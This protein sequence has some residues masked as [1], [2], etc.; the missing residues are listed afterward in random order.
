[1]E[2]TIKPNLLFIMADQFRWDGI[3]CIGNWTRTPH[4]NRLAGEGITFTQCV[5][6]SP[7]CL[8]ARTA[9]ATGLYPHQTGVWTNIRGYDLPENSRTWMQDVQAAGYRTS[10]F[11]KSHHHR[12]QG[13]LRDREYLMRAYGFED[14]HEI[15]GPR[16]S[17]EARSD[18]TDEWERQGLWQ[19]YIEDYEERYANKPYVARPSPLP[20]ALY[21]DIYVAQK[22]K[23]YLTAYEDERPWCCMLSFGG[24][25]EPWDTPEPYASS[26]NPK[27]MPKAIAKLTGSMQR[28]QGML[29]EMMAKP[30]YA[31][32]MD[33]QEIALLRANYAGNISLIDDQIGEVLGV[34]EKR[35]ELDNTVIVFTSDHGEMNGDF[36]L[37][38]KSNFLKSSAQVPLIVRTPATRTSSQAG[39]LL[40]T[41][42]ELMDVGATL[43]ELSG[44]SLLYSQ[45]ARS[46][47]AVMD[48][49]ALVHRTD[50]LSEINQETMLLTEWWKIVLNREAEAYLLFNVHN[51]PCEQINLAGDPNYEPIVE[52]LKK[53]IAERMAE[54]AD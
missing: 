46:L 33:E 48:N 52:K 35:G 49:P 28:P 37:L 20:L 21:A 4:L 23:Q 2:S 26:Y 13:D 50:A 19:S 1:M 29:D 16:A 12:Y 27:Q 10:L 45:N 30:E 6:N 3:E 14:V 9:L 7:L 40:E 18:M 41:V 11:G 47:C 17:M 39:S 24:P 25:H 34:L 5:T 31:P 51:D 15:A 42:V 38:Y 54:G 22:A 8:P 32:L 36:G 44:G 43:V 53:R